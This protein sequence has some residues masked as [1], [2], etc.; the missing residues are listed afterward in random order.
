MQDAAFHKILASTQQISMHGAS[1]KTE[2]N[3]I[4][5]CGFP[6]HSQRVDRTP[7]LALQK[8]YLSF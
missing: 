2:N 8:Y 7:D 3:D 4:S 5:V 1:G 6:T